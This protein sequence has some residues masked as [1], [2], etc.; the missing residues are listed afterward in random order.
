MRDEG[1]SRGRAGR[2]LELFRGATKELILVS[3]R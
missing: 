1:G 3:S 2:W